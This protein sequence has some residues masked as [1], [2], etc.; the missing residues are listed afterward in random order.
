MAALEVFKEA[1]K[2]CDREVLA[3]EIIPILWNMSL[4]PLLNL[5]QVSVHLKNKWSAPNIFVL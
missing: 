3:T 1:G 5:D 2:V 4:G